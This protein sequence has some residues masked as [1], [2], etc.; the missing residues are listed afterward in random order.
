MNQKKK[1][2][3]SDDELNRAVGGEDMQFCPEFEHCDG[4]QRGYCKYSNCIC[5]YE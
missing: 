2:K 1:T 4:S 3:L 5:L